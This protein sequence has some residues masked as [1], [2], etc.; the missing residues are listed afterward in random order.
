MVQR[1]T[2][3]FFKQENK[4]MWFLPMP[5]NGKISLDNTHDPIWCIQLENVY[6]RKFENSKNGTHQI[7]IST[8]LLFSWSF[9]VLENGLHPKREILCQENCLD[10][11]EELYLIFIFYFLKKSS[12]IVDQISFIRLCFDDNRKSKFEILVLCQHLV[13]I[14]FD[15]LR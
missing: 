1:L 11:I 12:Q 4:I 9:F 14:G 6:K 10:Q 8:A 5:Y 13:A 3:E 15:W 2:H 7:T